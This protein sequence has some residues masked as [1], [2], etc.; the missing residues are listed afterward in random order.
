MAQNFPLATQGQLGPLPTSHPPPEWDKIKPWHCASN[1]QNF[2][3]LWALVQ[4]QIQV[5]LSQTAPAQGF[6]ESVELLLEFQ[7]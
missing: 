2:R 1:S 6:T 3:A 4:P 7:V 5:T